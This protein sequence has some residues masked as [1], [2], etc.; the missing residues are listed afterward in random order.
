MIRIASGPEP[1]IKNTKSFK[2]VF[3]S[4]VKAAKDEIAQQGRIKSFS[5]N[6]KAVEKPVIGKLTATDIRNGKS[7]LANR[8]IGGKFETTFNPARGLKS[9]DALSTAQKAQF[10]IDAKTPYTKPGKGT[11]IPVKGSGL[12]SIAPYVSNMVN[13]FRKPPKPAV[14][15]MQGQVTLNRV[16]NSDEVNQIERGIRGADMSASREMDENTARSVKAANLATRFNQLSASNERNNN[17]NIEIGNQESTLNANIISANLNKLDQRDRDIVEMKVA[18]QAEGSANVANAAD[19]YMTIK[20]EEALRD[21]DLKKTAIVANAYKAD[22]ISGRT[23]RDIERATPGALSLDYH[24]VS[25]KADVT[26]LTN[27][28]INQD[29]AQREEMRKARQQYKRFGGK[30]KYRTGGMLSKMIKI[31]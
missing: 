19:K 21:L 25:R 24:G 18:Q 4:T 29:V 28:L 6:W 16:N 9:I 13:A 27:T 14:P 3:K 2:K 5:K 22:G 30:L 10:G 1:L 15:R 12:N 20:N 8:P 11:K 17:K 26:N 7:P 23:M 31:N